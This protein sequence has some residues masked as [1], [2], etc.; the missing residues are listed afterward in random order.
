MQGIVAGAI[1]S[2][3][4]D[5]L[6]S[7]DVIGSKAYEITID[8]IVTIGNEESCSWQH[9][10]FNNPKLRHQSSTA[11]YSADYRSK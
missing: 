1:G 6:S 4:N 3:S 7:F 11:P 2:V 8:D 5:S 9:R 10:N